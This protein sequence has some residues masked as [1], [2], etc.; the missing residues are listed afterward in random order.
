MVPIQG[1]ISWFEKY[2]KDFGAAVK[3]NWRPWYTNN[4]EFAGMVWELEGLT[5]ISVSGAG[6]MVPTDRPRQAEE[7][8]NVFVGKNNWE[9][10]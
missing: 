9:K 3:K 10:E 1:T 7:I 6:H 5:F 2:K 8:L 4:N